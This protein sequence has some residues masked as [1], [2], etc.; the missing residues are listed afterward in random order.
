MPALAVRTVTHSQRHRRPHGDRRPTSTVNGQGLCENCNYIH[1]T[2]GW[3]SRPDADGMVRLTTP[4][5]DT[6]TTAPPRLHPPRVAVVDI[7]YP[8]G[9]IPWVGY[10]AA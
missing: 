4:A 5:G 8:G 2:L 3:V 10:Q 6:H 9:Y 7:T 1:A